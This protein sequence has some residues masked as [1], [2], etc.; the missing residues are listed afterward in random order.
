MMTELSHGH[1]TLVGTV[2]SNELRAAPRRLEGFPQDLVIEIR[3][4]H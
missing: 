2:Y 3:N 1:C 4:C